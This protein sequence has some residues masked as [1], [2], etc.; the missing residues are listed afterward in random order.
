MH[1]VVLVVLDPESREV[2]PSNVLVK[3]AEKIGIV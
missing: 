1:L 3:E 2:K